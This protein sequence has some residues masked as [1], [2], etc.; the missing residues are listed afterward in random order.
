MEYG[1]DGRRM[2]LGLSRNRVRLESCYYQVSQD[3]VMI[4]GNGP[5]NFFLLKTGHIGCIALLPIGSLFRDPDPYRDLL[6]NLGPYL[7]FF[8]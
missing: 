1:L 8:L 6:A 2:E 4:K 7:V 5:S 3:R